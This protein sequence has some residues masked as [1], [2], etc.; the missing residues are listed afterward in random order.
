VYAIE[1]DDVIELAREIAA[2]NGFGERIEFIQ[3][4]STEVE[5]P[6]A[7]RRSRRRDPRGVAP[8][9]PQSSRR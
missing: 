7:G 5:L 3:A 8:V 6:R 2:D 4:I 9:W 1:P